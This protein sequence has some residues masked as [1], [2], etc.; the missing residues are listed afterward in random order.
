MTRIHVQSSRLLMRKSAAVTR[1]GR[2]FLPRTHRKNHASMMVVEQTRGR[3][4]GFGEIGVW[5]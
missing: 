4:R 2:N 1:S 3:R 5:R